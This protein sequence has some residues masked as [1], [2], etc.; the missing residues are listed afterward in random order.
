MYLQ[1]LKKMARIER[2]L[3]SQIENL[4]LEVESFTDDTFRSAASDNYKQGGTWFLWVGTLFYMAID[5]TCNRKLRLDR[6]SN[7]KKEGTRCPAEKSEIGNRVI[8]EA[9]RRG[10]RLL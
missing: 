1:D 3:S 4:N 5:P 2:S 8:L 9:E 6:N 7:R 10:Y